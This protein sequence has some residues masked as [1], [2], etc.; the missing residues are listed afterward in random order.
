MPGRVEV[1]AIEKGIGIRF[2]L[3]P[4]VSRV[5]RVRIDRPALEHRERLLELV[6]LSAVD[7]VAG[8]K[9]RVGLKRGG[10]A[11]RGVEDLR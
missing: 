8:L 4:L 3:K 7:E 10:R 6:C 2:R 5:A 9:N 1:G 11:K